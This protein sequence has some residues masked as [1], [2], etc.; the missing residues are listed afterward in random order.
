MKHRV[1]LL[2]LSLAFT[3]ALSATAMA[4][5]HG[6]KAGADNSHRS[7]K[8]QAR[9][10]FR[11]PYRT[12]EFFGVTPESKV[13]EIM[14]GGGW[15]TEILAPLLKDN[16]QLVAAHYPADT[17]SDYR[18]RSRANFE[19]KMGDNKG[20][21]GK[22][23]IADFD[24][25][26]GVDAATTDA[27]VVVTFRGLHGL[28]NGGDLAAAFS[29]FK[30]MLK[31]GGKLGVVQHQAPEGYNPIQTGRM[32]YL[33]KSHV[34]A[35][36]QAAGFELVQEAYF[37]NNAKDRIVQDGVEGGVWTLPPS[38]RTETEKEKYAKVGESNRMTL[39]F[40]K[41]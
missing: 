31:K 32:G 41:R 2:T 30:Q 28:Q 37:H 39:L 40:Q 4:D 13:V 26:A 38:L 36:A 7:E 15:Y 22:V 14:P 19:K 6:L 5:D 16:G 29:Q 10:E 1:K 21:Y 8:N 20:V 12:L 34:I 9:D 23:V 3:T 17:K 11:Q 18:K 33:P 24:P 35:V 27:D 25:R